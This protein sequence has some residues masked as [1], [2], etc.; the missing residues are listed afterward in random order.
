MNQTTKDQINV[1]L[2][3]ASSELA[4]VSGLVEQATRLLNESDD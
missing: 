3:N 1:L 2:I 4:Q